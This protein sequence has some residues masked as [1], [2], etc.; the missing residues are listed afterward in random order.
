[1]AE[2]HNTALKIDISEFETYKLQNYSLGFFNI[3]EVFATPEETEALTVLK[4]GPVKR[5]FA[6]LLNRPVIRPSSYVMEKFFHF[7]REI[8]TLS[9]NV[10]LDG[11]WQSEKYFID[12]ESVIREELTVK[13]LQKGKD[14]ELGDTMSACESVS[15]HIRRGDYVSDPATNRIH[16][17]CGLDYYRRAVNEITRFVRDP[18]FFIFSDDHKWARDNLKL[19]NR[20]TFVD[21]NKADKNYEDLRMMGQCKHNIIANSTF[22][23]WGAWLNENMDK[24]VIAPATWFHDKSRNAGDIIPDGWLKI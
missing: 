16:G 10:Y 17:I 9:D 8:L 23:W 1:L 12:I 18:H 21:H 3:R 6:G 4:Q 20:T 13:T 5:S 22:S 11:Y 19:D 14:R 15:L 24:I 2:I 7:D